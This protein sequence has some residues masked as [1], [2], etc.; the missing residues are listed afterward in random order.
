VAE[1]TQALAEGDYLRAIRL[2]RASTGYPD[3]TGLGLLARALDSVGRHAEADRVRERRAESRR[4]GAAAGSEQQGILSVARSGRL[5]L[6]ALQRRPTPAEASP[7]DALPRLRRAV[8]DHR[9]VILGEENGRPEHWAF[10]AR[11][12]PLLRVAGAT[13]LALEA[14]DQVALD[15]A[16]R[17]GRVGPATDQCSHEPRRASMLRAALGAG[18]KLV[19]FDANSAGLVW[20]RAHPDEAEAHRERRM[21]EHI[22]E[23]ILSRVPSARVVVWTGSSHARK[24]AVAGGLRTMAQHLQEITNEEPYSSCQLTGEGQLSGVDL[25]IRHPQPRY[26]RGRPDWLRSSDRL[27]VQGAIQPAGEYLVQLHFAAEGWAGTPTDQLLTPDDG[28]FE[29]L[30]PPDRYYLRVWSSIGQV[31]ETRPLTVQADIRGLWLHA[32][33]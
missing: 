32:H 29:L 33:G 2:L 14:S 28:T 23:R 4:R 13:H 12:L 15:Q 22:A 21:A 6:A 10:G 9:L 25:L 24:R 7:E 30:V 18:L 16:L 17:E 19:A 31:V 20:M 8:A 27:A 3:P 26:Q 5:S 1:G 11:V